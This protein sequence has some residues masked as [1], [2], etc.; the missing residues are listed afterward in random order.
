M[1]ASP[2]GVGAG[3]AK[4][5]DQTGIPGIAKA[6]LKKPGR[7]K[8]ET[9]EQVTLRIDKDVLAKFRASGRGWQSRVNEVLRKAVS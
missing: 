4:R 7:P 5:Q 8:G 6:F 9:K 1:Q 3:G 2:H